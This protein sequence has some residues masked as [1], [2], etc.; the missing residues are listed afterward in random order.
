MKLAP[1]VIFC[2]NRPYHLKKTLNSLK[3]NK[4]S[5]QSDVWFFSDGH[6]QE[7]KKNEKLLIEYVQLLKI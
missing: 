4:L 6:K 3:K 2:Y 7:D 1:I 5:K